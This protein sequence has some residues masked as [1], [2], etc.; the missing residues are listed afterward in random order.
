MCHWRFRRRRKVLSVQPTC[1]RDTVPFLPLMGWSRS[2]RGWWGQRCCIPPADA[3]ILTG[4][5]GSWDRQGALGLC[6]SGRAVRETEQLWAWQ[7]TWQGQAGEAPLIGAGCSAGSYVPRAGY[8]GPR[9]DRCGSPGPSAGS[10][11]CQ[12]TA[13]EHRWPGDWVL[14]TQ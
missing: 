6:R 7:G 14:L 4:A 10:S 2:C 12:H 13:R 11:S 3:P 5:A 1:G 8:C 9:D